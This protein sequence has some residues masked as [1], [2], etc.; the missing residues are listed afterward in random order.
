[1]SSSYS[2]IIYSFLVILSNGES[3]QYGWYNEK[4]LRKTAGCL[5]FFMSS[6]IGL[7]H[8]SLS[9]CSG[10]WS[11]QTLSAHCTFLMAD[12]FRPFF[13]RSRKANNLS[14][15]TTLS[16]TVLLCST[17][18]RIFS[19]LNVRS[20]PSEDSQ[21]RN[22]QNLNQ[23]SGLVNV[24]SLCALQVRS[25]YLASIKYKGVTVSGWS[26][27]PESTRCQHV[28]SYDSAHFFIFVLFRTCRYALQRSALLSW[29]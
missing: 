23:F 29:S 6:V 4:E 15:V 5:P 1:M 27:C 20:V 12:P 10:R 11:E 8:G 2:I 22:Y 17:M 9:I 18:F 14:Y 13:W 24:E 16:M 28:N 26:S 19:V 3:V 21:L 7:C 25:E